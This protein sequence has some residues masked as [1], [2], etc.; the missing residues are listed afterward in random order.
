MNVRG[1]E[2]GI[3]LHRRSQA[4]NGSLPPGPHVEIVMVD[5]NRVSGDRT[6]GGA[7]DAVVQI[8]AIMTNENIS[9]PIRGH[10]RQGRW[11]KL[12]G[13]LLAVL[14]FFWLAKKVGWIPV[15]AGGS[16]IFWPVLTANLI[17]LYFPLLLGASMTIVTPNC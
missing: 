13:I 8:L 5:E 7:E 11:H 2:I 1:N 14:G 15:A 9:K 4:A 3:E 6:G 10:A 17:Q 12:S 16:V